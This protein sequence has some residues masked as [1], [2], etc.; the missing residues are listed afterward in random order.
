MVN[1]SSGQAAKACNN[2]LLATT[3]IGV[4]EAFNLGINLGLDPEKVV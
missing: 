1:A 3:M 4:G 2:M